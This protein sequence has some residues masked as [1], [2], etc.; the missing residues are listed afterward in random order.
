MFL[1]VRDLAP[2]LLTFVIS[3][4]GSPSSLFFRDRVI[5]SREEVQS[6]PLS[7]ALFASLFTQ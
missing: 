1:A 6:D 4:Y 5:E 3:A 2:Q 7:P